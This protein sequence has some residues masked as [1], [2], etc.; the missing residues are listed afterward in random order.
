MGGFK[1]SALRPEDAEMADVVQHFLERHE[2]VV[3]CSCGARWEGQ[4]P[5]VSL[6]AGA[7]MWVVRS[8]QGDHRLVLVLPG[9]EV[10]LRVGGRLGR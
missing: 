8:A 3:R 9:E 4:S 10:E 6:M 7:H 2:V 1:V 5:E